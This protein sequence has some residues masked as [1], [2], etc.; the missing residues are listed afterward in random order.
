MIAVLLMLWL[1]VADLFKSRSKLEAE[2]PFLRHQ[3]NIALRRAPSRM[4]LN[5]C[6]RAL[7]VFMMRVCAENLIRVNE[8]TESPKL[9]Q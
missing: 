7:L 5:C 1:F 2:N 9:A 6:D 8:A 3:L 4:R